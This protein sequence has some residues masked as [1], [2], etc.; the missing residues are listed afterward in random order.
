MWPTVITHSLLS[1][2][3]T[4]WSR[5]RTSQREMD[6]YMSVICLY[7][8]IWVSYTNKSSYVCESYTATYDHMYAD[9]W[10]L[11]LTHIWVV[12][13]L[14]DIWLFEYSYICTHIWVVI[15]LQSYTWSH[16]SILIYEYFIW[17]SAYDDSYM[18]KSADIWFSY[19][20]RKI[21]IYEYFQK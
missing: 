8:H 20:S 13:C 16:M 15:C 4:N 14:S 10:S 12:I 19:M 7:T 9:I 2:S 21:L 5:S 11:S 3:Y 6:S 17:V 18:S 1:N